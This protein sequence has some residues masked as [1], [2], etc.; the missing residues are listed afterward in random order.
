MNQTISLPHLQKAV[1]I[2]K[3]LFVL[4]LL[5]FCKTSHGQLDFGALDHK[6]NGYK[7]V[8][9]NNYACLIQ[10]DDKVLYKKDFEDYSIKDAGALGS[11]SQWLTAALVMWYVDQGKISLE[12][13]VSDYMPIFTTYGKKYISVR[14]CLTHQTGIE[15][16]KGLAKLFEKNKFEDLEQEADAYASK[17][18]ILYNPGTAFTYNSI[19]TNLA[20]RIVEI[21]SK[22]GFEQ[23]VAEKILRPLAMKSTSFSGGD[24]VS[25]ASSAT[26]TAVDMSNFLT[27]LL[28]KGTF[29]GKRILSE[30][31]VA[32]ME[33][34]Q[35]DSSFMK[36][37]PVPVKGFTYGMGEWILDKDAE[38]KSTVVGFPNMYG[39]LFFID[40]CKGYTFVLL[41][42]DLKAETD[43][44]LYLD[45]KK[46][47][48]GIIPDNGCAIK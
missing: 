1:T 31:A 44:S 41:T 6:L 20:A 16:P 29:M 26:S 25:P 11:A 40:K 30:K 37:V 43:R 24:R 48:D 19:G 4:T 38:G 3:S 23:M 35:M 47:I 17:H 12:D 22:K 9:G 36:Y 13:K 46:T 28:N 34:L 32:D 21:V 27:M 39:S 15:S 7:T 18:E 45:I 10:K 14:H 42:N 8:L 5:F 2:F 33:T